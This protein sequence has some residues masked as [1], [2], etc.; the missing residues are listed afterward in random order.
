MLY[1]IYVL[2]VA[3]LNVFAY[4]VGVD[5]YCMISACGILPPLSLLSFR[6]CFVAEQLLNETKE[7]HKVVYETLV[8]ACV[9]SAVAIVTFLPGMLYGTP[10][11]PIGMLGTFGG[12]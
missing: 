10:S 7:I 11:M 2:A 1:V 4:F 6:L 12:R 3:A 5:T 9:L 8:A